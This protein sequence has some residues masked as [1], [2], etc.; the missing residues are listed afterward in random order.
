ARST[1]GSWDTRA[2]RRC[3]A[4]ASCTTFCTGGG[5]PL[6]GKVSGSYPAIL[7]HSGSPRGARRRRGVLGLGR[8]LLGTFLLVL[9]KLLHE[10]SGGGRQ[11]FLDG[12]VLGPQ[13]PADG[14]EPC[15]SV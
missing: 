12:V 9:L 13:P 6:P 15:S 2:P 1:I 3:R 11:R 14:Q 4:G 7:Q 10:L 5:E 8:P